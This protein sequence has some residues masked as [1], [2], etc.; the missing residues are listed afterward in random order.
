[1]EI[2]H[3]I[4]G[5]E[6][7][8]SLPLHVLLYRFFGWE[9]TMP[10]FSHLPLILKPDGKGKLSKRDGDR[11]GIPVFPLDWED[12]ESGEKASGFKE[13]GF[14]PEAFLNML[15]FLGWNPGTEQELFSLEE[16]IEAFSLERVGKA[17]ARFDYEKA[18]WF[19]QQHL[20]NA[21]ADDLVEL[22]QGMNPEGFY[23]RDFLKS[24]CDLFRDR[25]SL[26]NEL[27][28]QASYLLGDIDSYDEKSVR[29]KWKAGNEQH[30]LEL[31]ARLNK[32]EP[33]NTATIESAVKAFME[34][35]GLGFGAVLPVLRLAICGTMQG[36]S[37]FDVMALLGK[38]KVTE[39]L[40]SGITLFGKIVS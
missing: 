38:E 9:D 5:E 10:V 19:N 2:T 21:S 13:K 15:A 23:T 20:K 7:L 27:P 39:R 24:V 8:P 30:F 29:K 36:P 18:K 35:T 3:V 26:I 32:L 17:G 33:F 16:L 11:L 28:E 12:P 22:V 6:W 34:E 40:E 4:R 14:L 31:K 37:I 25:I 1:M